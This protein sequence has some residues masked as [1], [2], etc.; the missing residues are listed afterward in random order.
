ML[1]RHAKEALVVPKRIIS[2]ETDCGDPVHVG[3]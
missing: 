3:S 1:L 2:V